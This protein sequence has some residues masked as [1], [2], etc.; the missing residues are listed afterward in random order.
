MDRKDKERG[1]GQRRE[2][3]PWKRVTHVC[4]V[5]IGQAGSTY[6]MYR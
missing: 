4:E 1:K 5:D 3:A 6:F 2:H